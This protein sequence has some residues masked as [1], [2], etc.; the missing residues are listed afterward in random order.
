M[1]EQIEI[2]QTSFLNYPV[3]LDQ[4]VLSGGPV[5]EDRGFVLHRHN[6]LYDSS[7]RLSDDI[8]VTLRDILSI[9]GTHEADISWLLL[10]TL[11]GS[12]TIRT[13]N[14]AKLMAH[15]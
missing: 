7:I 11:V 14:F 13:R 10:G 5:A 15:N 6:Q 9:L 1:L 4:P 8:T 2:E 12:G 3:V